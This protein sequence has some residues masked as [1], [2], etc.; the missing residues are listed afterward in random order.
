MLTSHDGGDGGW[1]MDIRPSSLFFT[2]H[3]LS[4]AVPADFDFRAR[5]ARAPPRAPPVPAPAARARS[6]PIIR[7]DGV[8]LP[9]S[10]N[11]RT[12]WAHTLYNATGSPQ[13]DFF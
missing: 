4:K 13:M 9:K 5:P 11:P 1:M 2:L 12:I 6:S 10:V 3:V 8:Y 7:R